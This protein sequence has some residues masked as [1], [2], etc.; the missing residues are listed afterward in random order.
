VNC[1]HCGAAVIGA[2]RFCE[3]CGNPVDMAD[4]PSPSVPDREFSMTGAVTPVP[5]PELPRWPETAPVSPAPDVAGL[6]SAGPNGAA[7]GAPVL[8][9]SPIR[10][11]FGEVVWR[12]YEAVRLRRRSRGTGT[13]Y[14]TDARVVFYA[15]AKGRGPQR[16]SALVQQ[17]RLA[18]VTGYATWR[19]YHLST[20]LMVIALGLSFL[21]LITL[22][23]IPPLALVWLALLGICIAIM[24]TD[25]AQRA[26][27]GVTIYARD[28]AQS[29]VSFGGVGQ[30]HPIIDLAMRFLFFPALLFF[31]S[32]TAFDVLLGRPGE[33]SS[34]IIAEL[35]ALIMD[36]QTRGTLAGGYWQVGQADEAGQLRG[37]A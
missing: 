12:Q 5:V 3:D 11:G 31:R 4:R 33:D 1:Q 18:D 2:A 30:R 22:F 21:T 7:P 10:L 8:R 36:L 28:A 23:T 27:S 15:W 6:D 26:S 37:T 34:A 29:A 32:R 13:L 17:V 9:G 25:A 20:P 24:F 35:G 14:V 19:S 16:D